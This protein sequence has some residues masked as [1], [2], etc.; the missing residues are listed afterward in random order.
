MLNNFAKPIVCA[1]NGYAIGIGCIITFC[2]DLII[3]SEKAE[4]R[5]PQVALGI[6]PAYG[7]SA[8]L[9]RW[10]G[11]GQAMRVAM[12]FPLKGEEAH[13]IG[14]AQWCVPHDKLMEQAIEVAEHIAGMPPLAAR[15]V[16]E[17]MNRSLDI[18]NITDA[19]LADAYRFMELEFTEDRAEA[20][21][22]WREK[23]TR[24]FKGH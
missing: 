17:S 14:L 5:L 9:A 7:G 16:K 18:P 15:L 22:A 19:A 24:S 12:G 4:W 20:H 1:V 2:C 6:I 13:R 3:A 21:D 10:V 8:R 11:R 23:R